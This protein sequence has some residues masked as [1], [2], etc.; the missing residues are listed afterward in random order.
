M[1]SVA[2][3]EVEGE[4]ARAAIRVE[5]PATGQLLETS[6]VPGPAGLDELARRARAAQP[7][8]A[9]L[10][11][12]GRGRVLRR[13]QKWMLD[14]ASRILDVVVAESGKTYEDAEMVD[15]NYTVSALGFW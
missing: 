13:A 1:A 9:V 8:W 6:P 7:G 3:R 2:Q 5:N 12:P 15:L 14:N 11:Y 4:E 10:G